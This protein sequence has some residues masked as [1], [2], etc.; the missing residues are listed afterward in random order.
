[1]ATSRGKGLRQRVS[2]SH[3]VPQA[4]SRAKEASITTITIF[5][6]SKVLGNSEEIGHAIGKGGPVSSISCELLGGST[7]KADLYADRNLLA[8]APIPLR[9]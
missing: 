1:M 5:A 8:Q 2:L 9:V 4:A 7:K 6:C 3:E